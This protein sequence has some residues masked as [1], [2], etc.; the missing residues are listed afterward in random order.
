MSCHASLIIYCANKSVVLKAVQE[1]LQLILMSWVEIKTLQSLHSNWTLICRSDTFS[2]RSRLSNWDIPFSLF[3][4]Q[5]QQQTNRC[6]ILLL[7]ALGSRLQ[8]CLTSSFV[9]SALTPYDP[10]RTDTF[11]KTKKVTNYSFKKLANLTNSKGLGHTINK[12][13]ISYFSQSCPQTPEAEG[14]QKPTFGL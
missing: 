14:V 13:T 8:A 1:T 3:W 4:A 2:Y 5:R 9:P 6:N 12:Y 7:E 10:H 11:D